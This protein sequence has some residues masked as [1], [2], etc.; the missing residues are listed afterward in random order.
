ME[1]TCAPPYLGPAKNANLV[2]MFGYAHGRYLMAKTYSSPD[3][4]DDDDS[5][6]PGASDPAAEDE[7]RADEIRQVLG[8][9]G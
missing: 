5:T 1:A 8:E 2:M 6:M 7:A 9:F 3:V 4:D